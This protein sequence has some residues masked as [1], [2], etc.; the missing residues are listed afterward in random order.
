MLIKERVKQLT[1]LLNRYNYEYY[2]LDNP[3]V[4]DQEYDRLM[5]ELIQL[6]KENPELASNDSPTKRVGGVALDKFVKVE[7]KSQML[8][9]SNVFNEDE[10]RDFDAKIK[11][12]VS[13]YSYVAELK[14]DGLS[15]SL[16]YEN[17]LL[18][19]AATRGD[20][21]IG[22]DVT[23]N[24]RTIKSIPLNIPF[25]EPIE[26]RGE[27][28]MSKKAFEDA[29][30][31]RQSR[32][33]ELFK[34]PRNS[35][36]GTLRQ[37]D[38]KV[39]GK[40]KLDAFLYY[41]M[42]RD[43]K[44][45]HSEALK[46]LSDLG[47]KVNPLTKEC[48]NIDEVI[49]YINHISEIRHEL[50]YEIDG[51]VIKV[52]ELSLYQKIGYTAKSPK[53]AT[54]YK[55]PAEEVIT[56]LNAITFQVGRTGVITPV[57]ELSPVMVSGS[58]VKR[59][60]LHNEDY[61]IDKDIRIGDDVIIR[62]AGEIIPEVVKTLPERRTGNEIPF[63]MIHNCPKCDSL[64]VR[65]LEEADYYCLNPHCEAKK[66]EGLIHF[67]SRDAYNI[68]G[69]GEKVITELFND[70]YISSIS[71]IFK[72]KDYRLELMSKEGFGQKS[73]DNLLQAIET[74]KNNNLE[75]LVFGL[76]IRHVGQKIA[77]TLVKQ[78]PSLE[79][80]QKA[81]VEEL[82]EIDDIGEAIA[83]SLVA[84]FKEENNIR[85]IEDLTNLG[86]N[87]VYRSSAKNIQS[88]FTGKTVVL[89]GTLV[90]YSRNEAAKIIEDLGGKVSSSVSK[91]TDYILAGSEAGSKLTKGY[92]L[93]V[94]ILTEDDFVIMINE[95]S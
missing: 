26:V 9:L 40:R 20:G 2:V 48:K 4:T 28:F 83:M 53:W 41:L 79:L 68:E 18:K 63:Q 27:V 67:A 8:S 54:A 89:T 24:I 92:E 38:P 52:N 95:E 61:C 66:I 7:H 33:E 6:E 60:T 86:L 84:Y 81:T 44:P 17:G 56:H 46:F 42:N 25:Y 23:E 82:I 91:N 69:L 29:N 32:G 11:K 39:V 21:L 45:L 19:L 37:L 93:G 75:K 74:S 78:H 3:T 35:A 59:A 88:V 71:D 57:A 49:S 47:F 51:I 22:E 55:F 70:G 87:T 77:K 90:G 10:L 1:D 14:I 64:L 94:R 65:K 80:L 50:P 16:H 15:V 76:G 12:E 36:A 85:L 5:N 34:N 58:V 43:L 31:D 30:K 73:I 13:K 62:K 72:L